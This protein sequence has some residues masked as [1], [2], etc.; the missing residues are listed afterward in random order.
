M[1]QGLQA[2]TLYEI[3]SMIFSYFSAREC[4]PFA[5]VCQSW[6]EPALSHI[7][8]EIDFK[9]FAWIMGLPVSY[10]LSDAD[11]RRIVSVLPKLSIC[12]KLILCTQTLSSGLLI[13]EE[14]WTGY[15][16]VFKYVRTIYDDSMHNHFGVTSQGLDVIARSWTGGLMFPSLKHAFIYSSSFLPIFFPAGVKTMHITPAITHSGSI[17]PV[18]AIVTLA[19]RTQ[20]LRALTISP[21][22]SDDFPHV[23]HLDIKMA[24]GIVFDRWQQL[25]HISF[26]LYYITPLHLRALA[27]LPYLE[28]INIATMPTTYNPPRSGWTG[29][30]EHTKHFLGP[31]STSEP[32]LP[33]GS[34]PSLHTFGIGVINPL[35]IIR[36]L[37]Q[38]NFPVTQIRSIAL[39][40]TGPANYSMSYG[41]RGI[42]QTLVERQ[43]QVQDLFIN[44]FSVE[45]TL[46]T[47]ISLSDQVVYEDIKSLRNLLHLR[48]ARMWHNLPFYITEDEFYNL[49]DGWDIET[50]VLNPSP[51]VVLDSPLSLLALVVAAQNCPNL[52]ELGL[53]VDAMNS[54]IPCTVPD[55]KMANLQHLSLGSSHIIWSHLERSMSISNFLATLTDHPYTL[56][57]RAMEMRLDGMED[58]VVTSDANGSL[59]FDEEDRQHWTDEEWRLVRILVPTIRER[60]IALTKARNLTCKNVL[61][62]IREIKK[63]A[64]IRDLEQQVDLLR[65][66]W[67]HAHS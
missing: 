13:N 59:Q 37:Q 28:T 54:D 57:P 64:R 60:N 63:D 50:L 2:L 33:V 9:L 20:N 18:S 3:L 25:Q 53:F 46:P 38:P 6:L 44:T 24:L 35:A 5:Q 22:N 32:S 8:S 29:P 40:I 65:R 16:S 19:N 56:L 67:I 45:G 7:Y 55:K 30:I 48:H 15:S 14:R 34:F 52:S 26:P 4:L 51:V 39:R 12:L 58:C 1:Q 31:G 27:I 61:S 17:C 42:I 10:G 49:T 36:L 23:R 11:K 43:S 66:L 21:G 41:I 47:A 62:N